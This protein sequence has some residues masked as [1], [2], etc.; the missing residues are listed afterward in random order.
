MK[1]VLLLSA[2]PAGAATEPRARV[3]P[4]RRRRTAL[5]GSVGVAVPVWALIG[6][7]AH[8]RLLAPSHTR[9]S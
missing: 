7:F 6:C 2:G 4:A 1:L 9:R 3:E 5:P 8:G